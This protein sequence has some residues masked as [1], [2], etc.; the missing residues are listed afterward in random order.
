MVDYKKSVT[1]QLSEWEKNAPDCNC[2]RN[3]KVNFIC[4][5]DKC[6]ARES[7]KIFCNL[8]F[9]EGKHPHFNPM[10]IANYILSITSNWALLKETV[11]NRVNLV[12]NQMKPHAPLI[13]YLEAMRVT[14]VPATYQPLYGIY[15]ELKSLQKKIAEVVDQIQ[16]YNVNKKGKE[17]FDCDQSYFQVYTRQLQAS[18]ILEKI[19]EYI[20]YFNYQAHLAVDSPLPFKSFTT[21]NKEMFQRLKFRSINSRIPA[22]GGAA[23]EIIQPQ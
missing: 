22:F 21:E 16:I 8:C 18:K 19:D 9:Q 12:E 4:L 10:M 1:N 2:R 6:P 15:E 23:A 11:E 5:E 20:I 17:M 3:Q 13:A 7:Q 14:R